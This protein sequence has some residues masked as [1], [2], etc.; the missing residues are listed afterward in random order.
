MARTVR[1]GADF[2][3]YT[4]SNMKRFGAGSF[5]SSLEGWLGGDALG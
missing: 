1:T 2:V 5:E 3:T 4:G